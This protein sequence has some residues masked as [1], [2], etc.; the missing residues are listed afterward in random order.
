M[1]ETRFRSAAVASVD[2]VGTASTTA[3]GFESHQQRRGRYGR[4]VLRRASEPVASYETPLLYPVVNMVTGST[5]NGGGIWRY[6]C[7]DLLDGHRHDVPI[8]S[9][10]LMRAQLFVGLERCYSD[11]ARGGRRDGLSVLETELR[12]PRLKRRHESAV[13]TVTIQRGADGPDR[14]FVEGMLSAHRPWQL[15]RQH[16]VVCPVAL[17][18]PTF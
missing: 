13:V 9:Q 7:D 18:W 6:I 14:R 11:G 5:P 3:S 16:L 15:G 17:T 12:R 8:M 1:Q 4:L 10:V 2:T